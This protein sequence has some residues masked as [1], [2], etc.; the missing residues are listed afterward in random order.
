LNNNVRDQLLE[1]IKMDTVP[2]PETVADLRRKCAREDM[3][4][5]SRILMNLQKNLESGQD[6]PLAQLRSFFREGSGGFGGLRLKMAENESFEKHRRKVL[7]DKIA[8]RG[9]ESHQI[10]S[11]IIEVS[12]TD[13]RELAL[14]GGIYNWEEVKQ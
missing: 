2:S 12:A 4:E 13:S 11:K 8:E 6:D 3:E 14:F 9:V 10:D 7:E 5:L 1:W